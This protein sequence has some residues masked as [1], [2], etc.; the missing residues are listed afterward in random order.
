MTGF[1]TTRPMPKRH[2]ETRNK[3]FLLGQLR[4]RYLGMSATVESIA[5]NS[6]RSHSESA[7]AVR[8]EA[9]ALD[10]SKLI[11]ALRHSKLYRDY[12][13]TFTA[14]T[15]LPLGLRPVEFFGLPLHGNKNE[16]PFCSLLAERK[17]RCAGCL[18]TQARLTAFG[19][20]TAHSVQCRYGL[21]ESVVPILLGERIIGFLCTGQ[22]FTEREKPEAVKPEVRFS[23]EASSLSGPA[24]QLWKQSRTIE[25]MKYKAT[26][27]L[28]S[29]FAKQLS[30]LSNQLFIEQRCQE[31][32]VVARARQYIKA[33]K[34]GHLSLPA[35]AKAAGASMF[36]FCTLFHQ[37]TGLKLSEFVA[38]SR[39]EDARSLLTNPR[40]R[41]SEVA[42]EAGFGS[43]T[44]FNRAFRRVIGQ[45]P[46]EYRHNLA[47]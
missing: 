41:M 47:C 20:A 21:T 24:L 18:Q 26:V 37:T 12:D 36:H 10:D 30:A 6:D 33:N 13:R 27:H 4:A 23:L 25:L 32:A 40:L 11:N 1:S 39:V 8:S 17:S 35:V 2:A 3:L 16:N 22:V 43:V 14:A 5:G 29:F 15:G 28:L 44:A 45:S 7:R 38:R 42:F 19:G 9:T 46:S 31:P 34:R